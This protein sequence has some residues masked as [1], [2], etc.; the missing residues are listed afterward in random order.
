MRIAAAED[1]HGAAGDHVEE[2]LGKNCER[3]KLPET[4]AEQQQNDRQSA[5][6]DNRYRGRVEARMHLG[7]GLKEISIA[8]GG[9]GHAGSAHD[10]AVQSYEHGNRHGR[11]HQAGARVPEHQRHGVGGGAFRGRYSRG[12]QHILHRCVHQ[13]VK[14]AHCRHTPNQRER[15]IALRIADL[16]RHHVQVVP[17]VVGPER[18]HECREKAGHAAFCSRE[19]SGEVCPCA[20]AIGEADGHNSE[21]DR[22]L[23][24]GEQKLEFTSAA[25]ANVVQPR[26]QYRGRDR[27]QLA[28]GEYEGM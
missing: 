13:N 14:S 7:N 6:H 11:R 19:L 8:R 2:P 12:R 5:L 18:S 1:E 21:N 27:Y 20:S 15:N 3:E 23:Q 26:N 4:A 10:G 16:A 28:V 24:Q 25:D 17:A 9:K 22:N